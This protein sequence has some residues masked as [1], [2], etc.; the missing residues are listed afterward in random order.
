MC[1][2]VE[3]DELLPLT[4]LEELRN[5]GFGDLNALLASVPQETA[6]RFMES[7]AKAADQASKTQGAKAVEIFERT[8]SI[9]TKV[10]LKTVEAQR[11]SALF[12]CG[13]YF[14]IVAQNFRALTLFDSLLPIASARDDKQFLRRLHSALGAVHTD[15]MNHPQ[16]MEHLE[17]ALL[18]ARELDDLSKEAAVLANCCRVLKQM[19]L[20]HDAIAVAARVVDMAVD[21]EEGRLV[22][23]Q[24]CGI[25]LFCAHRL[26]D[27]ESALQFLREGGELI[28]Q[29]A[30]PFNRAVFEHNR[31]NYLIDQKDSETAEITLA[32]AKQD[33]L[34]NENPRIR[35]LLDIP[36]ALCEWAS[37][38]LPRVEESRRLLKRLHTTCR[39]SLLNFD[40]VLRALM[41]AHSN[42][43]TPAIA[44]AGM[45]YAKELVEYT[46]NNRRAKLYRQLKEKG[47]PMENA[48]AKGFDPFANSRHWLN[49]PPIPTPPVL[50]NGPPV[51]KNEELSA[52][53]DSMALLRTEAF[54]KEINTLAYA[55][56]ENWALAAEFFDD[57]TGQHCFRVG[58]LAEMLAKELNQDPRFCIQIGQAARLH[59]IGKIAVN[60]MILLKPGKLDPQET[61]AMR[62]HAQAGADM[63]FGTKD[64]TLQ[65][66]MDVARYHHEWWNG[67]GY[68]VGLSGERIPL[69]ARITAYADVYDALTNERPY[70]SAWSP[71]QAL[72]HMRKVAG[73]HFDPALLEPFERVIRGYVPLLKA[74]AIPGIRDRGKNHLWASRKNLLATISGGGDSDNGRN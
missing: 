16:A 54:R 22:R 26:N 5:E 39:S 70:K 67:R 13:Y 27:H 68:P 19:G 21:N 14:N 20:Y 58:Y 45:E 8:V 69:S 59:D 44:Q 52:I 60:E 65:L 50:P 36:Q 40:D 74:N 2:T 10:E 9:L 11:I 29:N 18:L 33:L 49:A 63:L 42:A 56:A 38:E 43:E 1:G 23:L 47:V 66:A 46:T 7:V 48:T 53:H 24:T 71:E 4:K 62:Q 17:Q 64:P 41:K 3:P 30:N 55:T 12:S 37:G 15:I 61:T 51:E 35:L 32:K 34:T 57:S 72:T 28:D 73:L 6:V 25:G 31:A